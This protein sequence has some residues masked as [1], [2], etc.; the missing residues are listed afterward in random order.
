MFVL[1]RYM[2][3]HTSDSFAL[4][5]LGGT[6]VPNASVQLCLFVL[7]CHSSPVLYFTSHSFIC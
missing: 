1:R 4:I 2:H 5:C 7:P 6:D 3:I